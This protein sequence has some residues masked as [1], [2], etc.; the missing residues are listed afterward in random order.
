MKCRKSLFSILQL[1]LQ[2]SLPNQ[3][4]QQQLLYILLCAFFACSITRVVHITTTV[5]SS[6]RTRYIIQTVPRVYRVQS[7]EKIR[8]RFKTDF[9]TLLY[10]AFQ[11]KKGLYSS[12]KETFTSMQM[13]AKL[14]SQNHNLDTKY[15]LY[16]KLLICITFINIVA[17]IFA[18]KMK[19][20]RLTG[21]QELQAKPNLLDPH[22]SPS[23]YKT[24]FTN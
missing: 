7:C 2:Y 6:E 19:V 9:Y 22:A 12:I 11:N 21:Y 13:K 8:I 5:R 18:G 4:I 15:R 17:S 20:F 14:T 16:R 23:F 1:L 3:N 10:T 24:S